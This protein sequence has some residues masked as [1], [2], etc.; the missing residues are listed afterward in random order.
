MYCA[1]RPSTVLAS[2]RL[3]TLSVRR[4][5]DAEYN[6]S[7]LAEWR[8]WRA[9]RT[10]HRT[11]NENQLREFAMTT[12]RLPAEWEEHEATWLSYPHN[13]KSFFEHLENAQEAFIDFACLVAEGEA[14]HINVNN[15]AMRKE[16]EEKIAARTK[17]ANIILHEFPT[18]DA[19]CRDHGAIIIKNET[20]KRIATNWQF[21]SWGGKYPHELDNMIA[22]KMAA[23]LELE[24]IDKEY[25]FEGGSIDTNGAGV[26]LTTESC[27]LNPNRNPHMQ[28]A[29]IEA[30]LK[31]QFGAHTVIW[32][33]DG[34]EG[35]D[36]DG[37][38]D[39]ITRFVS[40]EK[41]VTVIEENQD[42]ANYA[43]LRENFEMLNATGEFDIFALPMPDPL[44]FN[45]ERLPASYANFYISNKYVCVPIFECPQDQAALKTLTKLFPDRQVIG[46]DARAII[47]G[48]GTFHCLTQQIPK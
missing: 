2:A 1:G 24:R 26:M 32:L 20:G 8:G 45:G 15:E 21:N 48:L 29:D 4:A 46:I 25:V 18:N 31:A 12:Y 39:D 37:H 30:M 40:K 17:T 3:S 36:T 43:P 9:C 28:K 10:M 5:Q 7:K 33:K 14:V 19:W 34:I 38:I 6:R 47:I 41:I 27:L 35:D 13:Q 16:V 22:E 44:F 42:D 23:Y 11:Y